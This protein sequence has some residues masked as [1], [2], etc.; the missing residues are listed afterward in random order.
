[1][2]RRAFAELVG[3]EGEQGFRL[4]DIDHLSSLWNKAGYRDGLVH[5][6]SNVP[7]QEPWKSGTNR[8]NNWLSR[9][10]LDAAGT[11]G[12]AQ[13]KA[14]IDQGYTAPQIY[15]AMPGAIGGAKGLRKIS[16]GLIGPQGQFYKDLSRDRGTWLTGYQNVGGTFGERSYDEVRKLAA[17]DRRI[18]V[19]GTIGSEGEKITPKSIWDAREGVNRIGP[20]ARRLLLEDLQQGIPLRHD[21]ANI[22]GPSTSTPTRLPNQGYSVGKSATGIKRQSP[23]A[24][25][26]RNAKGTWGRGSQFFKDASKY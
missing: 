14:A 24:M 16:E 7:W 20:E 19:P 8:G 21:P 1:M 3:A 17:A 9:G 12:P 25:T 23:K 2:V 26:N 22:K 5:Q 13:Y 6:D 11:F 10:F 15:Q 18:G 4:G